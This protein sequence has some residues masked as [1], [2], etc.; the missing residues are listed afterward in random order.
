MASNGETVAD[1]T[2]EIRYRVETNERAGIHPDNCR[3]Y[4]EWADR[5]EAAHSREVAELVRIN[6]NLQKHFEKGSKQ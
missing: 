6:E 3:L 4:T 1:I 5:I 2:G